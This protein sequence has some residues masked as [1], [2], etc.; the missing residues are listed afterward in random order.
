MKRPKR[1]RA[2][3]LLDEREVQF[4]RHLQRTVRRATGVKRHPPIRN[5]IQGVLMDYKRIMELAGDPDFLK[6]YEASKKYRPP[7]GCS[8]T[9][10][11]C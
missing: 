1:V 5:I 6:S 11:L 3:I 9:N 4:I 8:S 2:F 10:E 7:K